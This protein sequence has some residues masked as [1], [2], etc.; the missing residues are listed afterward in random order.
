MPQ[1]KVLI[2]DDDAALVKMLDIRLQAEGFDTVLAVNGNAAVTL[3]RADGPD[4]IVLDIAM[5]GVTGVEV[6][7]RLES[8][9]SEDIPVVIITAYP[10]MVDQVKCY[11]S[12]KAWFIKPFDLPDLVSK[13]REV[14]ARPA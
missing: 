8:A 10:H 14:I 6:I 9:Q 7:Q 11:D 13:I 3:A 1:G 5:P 12:V 2:A 4:V